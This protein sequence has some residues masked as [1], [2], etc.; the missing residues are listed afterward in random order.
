MWQTLILLQLV[1]ASFAATTTLQGDQLK[2]KY[3]FA[4]LGDDHGLLTE[5]DL[6]I[7]SQKAD[8]EPFSPES[9]AYP[10]WQCFPRN[11][12]YFD[13]EFTQ[14]DASEK[15]KLAI[16]AIGYHKNGETQEY[17]SRRAIPISA[18]HAHKQDWNRLTKNQNYVCM[19]GIFIETQIEPDKGTPTKSSAWIFDRFKTAQ[20]C[21]SYFVGDC[22]LSSF[23]ATR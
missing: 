15:S 12:M 18:C 21:D 17:L 1:V 6:A 7:N 20:G 13:C 14:Y 2:A 22:R 19:S 23:K 5:E 3:P 4:L 9:T 8:P 10:Y 11:Q 16:L